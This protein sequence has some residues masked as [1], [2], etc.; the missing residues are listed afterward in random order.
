M[1]YEHYQHYLGELMPDGTEITGEMINNWSK[2]CKKKYCCVKC[3]TIA[4]NHN[5][6]L[7]CPICE[8]YYGIM[9]LFKKIKEN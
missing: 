2:D 9:P 3:G 6:I 7:L 8:S 5:G 1:S 4:F